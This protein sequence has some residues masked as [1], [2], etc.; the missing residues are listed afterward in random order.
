MEPFL[1][2][3]AALLLLFSALLMACEEE[4]DEAVKP[5]PRT[6]LVGNYEMDDYKVLIYDN[7]GIADTNH[8]IRKPLIKLQADNDMQADELRIDLL[9]FVEVTAPLYV[10][11]SQKKLI[12][13]KDSDETTMIKI[14]NQNF[15][16]RN[17]YYDWI[18]TDGT[19]SRVVTFDLNAKGNLDR[20]KLTLQFVITHLDESGNMFTWKGTVPGKKDK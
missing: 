17:L 1:K 15:E 7:A 18:I 6:N 8:V 9:E 5:D 12:R 16:I 10:S 14:I 2:P 11:P 3:L 13:I 19:Q 4:E 20:G